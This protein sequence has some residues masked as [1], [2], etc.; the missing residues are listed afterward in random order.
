[1][2]RKII[3]GFVGLLLLLGLSSFVS[4]YGSVYNYYGCGYGDCYYSGDYDRYSYSSV[5]E[6]NWGARMV[7]YDRVKSSRYV[8]GGG[9]ETSTTYTKTITEYPGYG[10]YYGGY[11][12]GYG[13]GY[14]GW[15]NSYPRYNYYRW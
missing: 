1:M 6:N 14:G 10:N 4:A 5:R 7:D 12:G 3:A 9:W 15:Y 8:R 2:V 11:Y 13:G